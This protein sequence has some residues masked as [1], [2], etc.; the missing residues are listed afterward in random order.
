MYIYIF[1]KNKLLIRLLLFTFLMYL[2]KFWRHTKLLRNIAICCIFITSALILRKKKLMN[3][4]VYSPGRLLLQEWSRKW[5]IITERIS[6]RSGCASSQSFIVPE[7]RMSIPGTTCSVAI[8]TPVYTTASWDQILSAGSAKSSRGRTLARI[9]QPRRIIASRH[10][11]AL[12]QAPIYKT[13]IMPV[14]TP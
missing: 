11:S 8:A 2:I 1:I 13:S 3:T 7:W 4:S 9:H 10:A 14:P 6:C 5:R 12:S